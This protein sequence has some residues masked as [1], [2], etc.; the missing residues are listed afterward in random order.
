MDHRVDRVLGFFSSRPNWFGHP[1]PPHPQVSVSPPLWF[2]GKD[3]LACGRGS[4]GS[5]IGWGDRHYGNLGL[6]I[7]SLFGL[8]WRQLICIW[9]FCWCRSVI[10]FHIRIIFPNPESLSLLSGSESSSRQSLGPQFG[11]KS[12]QNLSNPRT[13]L[14]KKRVKNKIWNLNRTM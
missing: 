7:L 1:P 3:R 11:R 10:F 5:Q 13:F 14:V 9:R 8:D 12:P 2:R 6:C 4:V